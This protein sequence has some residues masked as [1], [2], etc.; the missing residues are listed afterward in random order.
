M[1]IEEIW[2]GVEYDMI[3]PRIMKRGWLL[4]T[5]NGTFLLHKMRGVSGL[6][7]EML[8]SEVGHC[9]KEFSSM[10]S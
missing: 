6:E 8:A 10:A 1:D 3:W 2:S 5:R 4:W 7:E 9:R